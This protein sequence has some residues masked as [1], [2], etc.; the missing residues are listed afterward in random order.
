MNSCHFRDTTLID[1]AAID[2][3][4]S[5]VPDKE[6][7]LTSCI[8]GFHVYKSAW[9][10]T[11][12]K[13]LHCSHVEGNVRDPYAVKVLVMKLGI[14]VGHRPK[15]ISATCFLFLRKGGVISCEVTDERR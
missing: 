5:S 12:H 1:Y 9:T 13:I 7:Q 6:F 8:R 14:V 2:T 10:P 3:S 4:S 15:K 11:H